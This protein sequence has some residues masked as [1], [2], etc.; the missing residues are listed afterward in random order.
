MKSCHSPK[1][2]PIKPDRTPLIPA[3]NVVPCDVVL[4]VMWS[5]FNLNAPMSISPCATKFENATDG[6]AIAHILPP[7]RRISSGCRAGDV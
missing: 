3:S 1:T 7:R 2:T 4:S 5:V 6:I